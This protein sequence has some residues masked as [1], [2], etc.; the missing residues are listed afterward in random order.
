MT[1]LPFA[2]YAR[3]VRAHSPSRCSAIERRWVN[4]RNPVKGDR[5]RQRQYVVVQC[6]LYKHTEDVPHESMRRQ[7]GAPSKMQVPQRKKDRCE[8]TEERLILRRDPTRE[9]TVTVRCSGK[10]NHREPHRYQGR[11]FGMP[12]RKLTRSK[13]ESPLTTRAKERLERAA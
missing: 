10:K 8:A 9:D 4:E 11:D 12:L 7:F 2:K 3:G 5:R 1:P 13:Y 6:G